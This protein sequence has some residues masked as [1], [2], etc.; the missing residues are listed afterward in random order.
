MTGTRSTREASA[1]PAFTS[2]LNAMPLL[3]PM[4][5]TFGV[6]FTLIRRPRKRP[7]SK[8]PREDKILVRDNQCLCGLTLGRQ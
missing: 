5:A 8:L 2:G 4:V 3:Q 6:V 1:Q 7:F